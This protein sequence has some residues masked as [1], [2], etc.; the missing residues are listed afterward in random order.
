MSSNIVGAL[1]N[2]IDK[3]ESRQYAP[4]SNA[5]MEV[6]EDFFNNQA[7]T[8]KTPAKRKRMLDEEAMELVTAVCDAK[9]PSNYSD[10]F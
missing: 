3:V 10:D 1:C 8:F 7:L 5:A 4:A 2:D 9:M 6:Q